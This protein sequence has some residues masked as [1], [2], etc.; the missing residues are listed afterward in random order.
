MTKL[1]QIKKCLSNIWKS[2]TFWV[3]FYAYALLDITS[4]LIGAI[5][6][7]N[8]GRMI[9]D[10]VFFVFIGLVFLVEANKYYWP[11]KNTG[12]TKE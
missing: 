3:G 11:D 7:G 6:R 4:N 12:E 1:T 10:L 5:A 2:R 9:F 8:T